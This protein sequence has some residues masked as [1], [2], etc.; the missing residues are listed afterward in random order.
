MHVLSERLEYQQ[1]SVAGFIL[2]SGARVQD[3]GGPAFAHPYPGLR[4]GPRDGHEQRRH[5]LAGVGDREH[6]D[7]RNQAGEQRVFD[8]VLLLIL[9]KQ[10]IEQSLHV[11][12]PEKKLRRENRW[13]SMKP[14]LPAVLRNCRRHVG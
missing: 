11:W 10:T 13:A 4:N 6:A 2:R 5:L 14:T 1:R 8:E 3:T 9:G 7:E 12:S